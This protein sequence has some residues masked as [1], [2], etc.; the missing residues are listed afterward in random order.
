MLP[1]NAQRLD[2]P[3][4]IKTAAHPAITRARAIV[5]STVIV[6]RVLDRVVASNR[7]QPCAPLSSPFQA[8]VCPTAKG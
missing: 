5:G 7:V 1:Q 3:V 8:P 6:L 2:R 4:E